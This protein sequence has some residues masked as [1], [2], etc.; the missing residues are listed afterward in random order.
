MERG[1][2]G[3]NPSLVEKEVV[4]KVLDKSELKRMRA[5]KAGG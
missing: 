5:E 3:M 1:D 2:K 4:D